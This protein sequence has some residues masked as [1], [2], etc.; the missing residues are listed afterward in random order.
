MPSLPRIPQADISSL[1]DSISD[2]IGKLKEQKTMEEKLKRA[3]HQAMLAQLASGIAHEIRNP[4][5]FIS[6]SIDHLS[7]AKFLEKADGEG[8]PADLIRKTKAEIQRMNQMVTNFLDLGREL[9]IHLMI[10]RADLPVEEVLGLN[11]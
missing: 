5:N 4:L 7:T 6:L 9:I 10:L 11:S 1:A 2:M 3:E 8:G